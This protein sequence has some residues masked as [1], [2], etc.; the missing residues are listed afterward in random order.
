[1][2]HLYQKNRDIK[3]TS[4]D[5]SGLKFLEFSLQKPEV[6]QSPCISSNTRLSMDYAIFGYFQHHKNARHV[7]RSTHQ[8][9]EVMTIFPVGSSNG[10]VH[11]PHNG[12]V[13]PSISPNIELLNFPVDVVLYSGRFK[14]YGTFWAKNQK[15]KKHQRESLGENSRV[16]TQ[17]KTEF[18]LD[19]KGQ[20]MHQTRDCESL[21]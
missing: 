13:G 4:W 18:D 19:L 1:M 9:P 3:K 14:V 17:P 16:F 2:G 11:S 5:F 20:S 10:N 6:P 21:V 7:V 15:V 8:S 12:P